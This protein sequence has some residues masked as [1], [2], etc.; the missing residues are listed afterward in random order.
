MLPKKSLFF[1]AV[2][3]ILGLLAPPLLAWSEVPVDHARGFS[4]EREG[5]LTL[6]EVKN[7]WPGASAPKKYLLVPRGEAPGEVPEGASVIEVPVRSCVSTTTVVLGFMGELGVLDTLVGQGGKMY[8]YDPTPEQQALPEVGSG[9]NL[10]VEKIL[11]L[12]P[13]VLFAYIFTDA[14]KQVFARLEKAG[15]KVV[16]LGE[17]MENHPLGRAEWHRYVAP[18]FGLSS[19]GDEDFRR[20]AERYEELAEI[21]RSFDKKP[22]VLANS[23]FNGTWYVPGG[24]SWVA[25][26]FKD[27]GGEYL[28][29]DEGKTGSLALDVEAVYEKG[30]DADVWV[31]GGHWNFLDD[32]L[33]EEPRFENFRPF[34]AGMV[35]NNNAR[36]NAQGGNDYHQSGVLR[37]D[38]VLADLIDI[39]HPGALPGHELY[40][41]S[42]LTAKE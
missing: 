18:F 33:R 22:L 6:L 17:Y 28:W 40:Y 15:I 39:F 3:L 35:F 29:A 11:A 32:A 42:Q 30:R 27:A 41:Y 2:L 38:L 1:A 12:R 5:D 26:L 21:G 25:R 13:E 4:I 31:N 9:A 10:D 24:D 34:R 23:P 7:P 19:K 36:V 8:V 20:I 37:P 16:V 14:E